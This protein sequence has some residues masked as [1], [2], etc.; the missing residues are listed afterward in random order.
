MGAGRAREHLEGGLRVVSLLDDHCHLVEQG[1]QLPE[2]VGGVVGQGR[3]PGGRE[4]DLH[5]VTSDWEIWRSLISL[6]LWLEEPEGEED[7]GGCQEGGRAVG[8]GVLL[9]AHLAIGREEGEGGG[10]GGVSYLHEILGEAVLLNVHIPGLRV[11]PEEV[12]GEGP[13]HVETGER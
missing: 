6:Y 3:G 11:A 13:R 4:A 12:E 10:E 5:M 1:Q 7:G 8:Q 2:A 9:Q